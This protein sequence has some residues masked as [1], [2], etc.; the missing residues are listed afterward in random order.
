MLRFVLATCPSR[1]RVRNLSPITTNHAAKGSVFVKLKISA[2]YLGV[3]VCNLSFS[4]TTHGRALTSHC[5]GVPCKNTCVSFG[6]M[7]VCVRE[8]E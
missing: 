7:C 5:R 3:G 4:W 6:Q 8:S 2:T 1:V